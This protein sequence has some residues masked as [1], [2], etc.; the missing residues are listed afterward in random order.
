MI[1]FALKECLYQ[2]TASRFRIAEKTRV[3]I[4]EEATLRMSKHYTV[5]A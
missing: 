4:P 3:G 2:V 5:K 1:G